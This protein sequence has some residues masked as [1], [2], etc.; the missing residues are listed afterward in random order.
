MQAARGFLAPPLQLFDVSDPARAPISPEQTWNWQ[1]GTVWR[2]HTLALAVDAYES[3]FDDAIGNRTVA[4]ETVDFDEGRAI[5]RGVEG[6]GSR[7]VGGGFSLYGSGSVNGGRVS[8]ANGGTSGPVPTTPQATITGG[9]LF[10]RGGWNVS[11]IDRWVGGFFGDVGGAQ[12]INPVNQL[13]LSAGTMLRPRRATPVRVQAQL[14]NALDS[15]RIDGLAGYTAAAGTPLYW[16]QAGRSLI[17][18]ATALF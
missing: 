6:E 14:F 13:D 3:L 9:L 15:R 8:A 10:D 17:V 11:L 7:S 18:S 12:R 4:D 16:T 1:A 5:Y 2:S